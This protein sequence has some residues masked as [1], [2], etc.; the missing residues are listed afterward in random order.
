MTKTAHK[1][2]FT[3]SVDTLRSH[4]R[5]LECFLRER[6]DYDQLLAIWGAQAQ[7]LEGFNP[8]QRVPVDIVARNI[9]HVAQWIDEPN[10][11]LKLAPYSTRMQ[12]RL[13]FFF[14]ERELPLLDYFRILARYACISSEVM[15]VRVDAD[16]DAIA[17]GIV[18]NC[19]EGVS[20]HQL[21]GFA[22]A[23]CD[24]VR[25][26][27]GLTP[28]VVTFNHAK[29]EA[30]ASDAVYEQ[31]LGVAPRFQQPYNRIQFA[32]PGQD[33]HSR[34]QHPSA[35]GFKQ[36]QAMEAVKHREV[37][38]HHGAE[39]WVHRC[40]FLLEILML[41]GEP[42]KTLLAELLVVTPR[43]LQRH[44]E[45]EGTT[46][47]ALL[48]TLRQRLAA[49][50]IANPELNSEDIAFLLGYQDAAHFFRAFKRWFGVP[51]GQYRQTHYPERPS[52]QPSP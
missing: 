34:P 12:E 46:F 35:A 4:A 16:H 41:Y 48:D 23:I 33:Q 36:I 7:T 21:E 5:A 30:G 44:L 19:P 9:D 27:R 13:A 31:A 51:P 8:Q 26:A 29:P 32:N 38:Q 25:T 17:L 45:R 6:G 39:P 11:G 2:T 14:Q 47:R 42:T 1:K 50:H 40:H 37:D 18:P 52:E 49:S 28:Q 10:L 22:A 3:V 24:I 43:T 15:Q 20:I